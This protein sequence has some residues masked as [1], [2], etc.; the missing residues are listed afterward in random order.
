MINFK[1]SKEQYITYKSAIVSCKLIDNV[2]KK[3][4]EIKVD[5]NNLYGFKESIKAGIDAID[6]RC[7]VILPARIATKAQQ[8]D[9]NTTMIEQTHSENGI[10]RELRGQRKI[11]EMDM[12]GRPLSYYKDIIF[13]CT[14]WKDKMP[15]LSCTKRQVKTFKDDLEVKETIWGDYCK[16]IEYKMI[17]LSIE[18]G[19]K[20]K[21]D[22]KVRRFFPFLQSPS[23]SRQARLM[24]IEAESWDDIISLWELITHLNREELNKAF[25]G[26]T[27]G[28]SA[29]I[30][31]LIARL[32]SRASSSFDVSALGARYK[33]TENGYTSDPTADG[34]SLKE[35]I[36]SYNVLYIPDDIGFVTE[37]FR[38]LDRNEKGKLTQ[39][40]KDYPEEERATCP[41]DGQGMV[42][43]KVV[44][45]IY[46]SI[47]TESNKE[48][49]IKI[50]NTILKAF[51]DNHNFHE[52][53]VE[54]KRLIKQLPNAIQI[55]H[56]SKKGMVFLTDFAYMGNGTGKS[57]PMSIILADKLNKMNDTDTFK[58]G[59]I[60]DLNEYDVIIPESVRKYH[61]K[62]WAN[63]P[64]EVCNY[65][66][67]KSGFVNLNMQTLGALRYDDNTVFDS[68]IQHQL[69]DIANSLKD[70]SSVALHLKAFGEVSDMCFNEEKEDDNPLEH[71]RKIISSNYRMAFDRRVCDILNESTDKIL[72]NMSV[73]KI[74]VPGTYSYMVCDMYAILS[75]VL[76]MDC[77]G[78]LKSGEY[79]FN[80]KS[81]ECTWSRSPLLHPRQLKL[82]QLVKSKLFFYL[83]N[84]AIFNRY[85]AL[86]EEMGGGDFDG[87]ICLICPADT[88]QGKII[89]QGV[90][91]G[92]K[93]YLIPA[94]KAQ[95]KNI[96][97]RTES[98]I[99]EIKEYFKEHTERDQV[100][101]IT[102]AGSR[103]M[104]YANHLY[105]LIQKMKK[106]K[107]KYVAYIEQ[108]EQEDIYYHIKDMTLKDISI[109]DNKLHVIL[110]K[111]T[112]TSVIKYSNIIQT[113]LN[114]NIE[115]IKSALETKDEKELKEVLDKIADTKL[116]EDGQ[117][118]HTVTST[119]NT[120]DKI[121]NLKL[122]RYWKR[123]INEDGKVVY[124]IDE[125]GYLDR[126]FIPDHLYTKENMEDIIKEL[127]DMVGINNI[128]QGIEI[129]GAK[130][131]VYAKELRNGYNEFSGCYS[132]NCYQM[133]NREHNDTETGCY[134]SSS[135]LGHIYQ[136][137]KE[138][139]DRIM[140]LVGSGTDN[141]AYILALLSN[142]EIQKINSIMDDVMALRKEFTSQMIELKDKRKDVKDI[143]IVDVKEETKEKAI[144]LA[145]SKKIDKSLVA[146]AMYLDDYR[147]E[148]TKGKF[149]WLLEN[150]LLKILKRAGCATKTIRLSKGD[151]VIS[152]NKL[153]RLN[154]EDFTKDEVVKDF[155]EE[156]DSFDTANLIEKDGRLYAYLKQK[157]VHKTYQ[158]KREYHNF[159]VV[160]IKECN[161]S[162]SE[163]LETKDKNIPV[164]IAV[165]DR[166]EIC[167]LTD[168]EMIGK[169]ITNQKLM[170]LTNG[171]NPFY[172]VNKHFTITK[173]DGYK[174]VKDGRLLN[175][176]KV[177]DF[178]V[179]D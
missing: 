170:L 61:D 37:S 8:V 119:I 58:D 130:T 89:A 105:A 62:E 63:Y 81:C 164:Q 52:A 136:Y 87:D 39:E 161:S 59:A 148:K 133:R 154:D 70:P 21:L 108:S 122:P 158:Y 31:K 92:L 140:S 134:I 94:E 9:D 143:I 23:A 7:T 169:L 163:W 48:E 162:V 73:G 114:D 166:N 98:G 117:Y 165:N 157:E 168:G 44:L 25:T 43:L 66:Q 174:S 17:C 101:S 79:Y 175:S 132:V 113:I 145:E 4:Y 55:R 152:G 126:K 68:I 124:G 153:I 93:N 11:I 179:I 90:R 86:W 167:C 120:K 3:P 65:L 106:E 129:D 118:M 15:F 26:S 160:G 13:H 135:L 56:G 50:A 40:L 146:V 22:G 19:I 103:C 28:G 88:E 57:R 51:K 45:D 138:R 75:N 159:T 60:I 110:K 47:S 36:K 173:L 95:K 104:E 96:D 41:G 178:K 149:A 121:I 71:I 147:Q 54:I 67:R 35:E 97:F 116:G 12:G 171:E 127:E 156:L 142:K 78:V 102:N 2:T 176:I 6:N 115:M 20:V 111:S 29:V 155:L 46:V 5:T 80:N 64:L 123:N 100:G 85:D 131:G 18:K 177:I 38:S 125:H 24:F 137:V 172:I 107:I 99:K 74:K 151:F 42:S 77:E 76:G 69:D 141:T 14:D 49:R 83:P 33:L 128:L 112:K 72:D 150:E 84:C 32:S 53:S 10:S 34:K 30:S 109:I 27:E 1:L 139:K 16:E 144:K 82:V 91:N